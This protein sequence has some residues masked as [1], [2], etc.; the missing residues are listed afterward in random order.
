MKKQYDMAVRC[1]QNIKTKITVRCGSTVD[2]GEGT[3]VRAQPVGGARSRAYVIRRARRTRRARPFRRLDG[4]PG[5]SSVAC[6]APP[7]ARR[8]PVWCTA[9]YSAAWAAIAFRG[10]TLQSGGSVGP[11]IQ[12]YKRFFYHIISN[13]Q[14]SY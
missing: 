2:R 4:R 3:A 5:S 8:Q 13:D 10:H 1:E 9:H 6:A 12:T 7:H 14:A 11:L